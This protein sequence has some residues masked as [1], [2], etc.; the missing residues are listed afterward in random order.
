[1]G[2]LAKLCGAY[3]GWVADMCR[4]IRCAGTTWNCLAKWLPRV[5]S[6]H[7]TEQ[8]AMQPVTHQ[9]LSQHQTDNDDR[10]PDRSPEGSETL[11]LIAWAARRLRL[12][13]A[14]ITQS[15]G[16]WPGREL[17]TDEARATNETLHTLAMAA[18]A[19]GHD[20]TL[21]SP[22][23]SVGGAIR[24]AL[25]R[26]LRNEDPGEPNRNTGQQTAPTAA[27]RSVVHWLVCA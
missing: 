2:I 1:M 25:A 7:I 15:G 26:R 18:R 14:D 19:A 9:T 17:S 20:A 22:Q 8:L 27:G 6:I 13:T 4:S 5:M 23:H 21:L 24:Q 11:S 3:T 10:S 12:T 16:E